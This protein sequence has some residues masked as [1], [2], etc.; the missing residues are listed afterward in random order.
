MLLIT[1]PVKPVKKGTE[2]Y[3]VIRP[4]NTIIIMFILCTNFIINCFFFIV[5]LQNFKCPSGIK[6]WRSVYNF[7]GI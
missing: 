3:V 2:N 1:K 5:A 6:R 7:C 4:V